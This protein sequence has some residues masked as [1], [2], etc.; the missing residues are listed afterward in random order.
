MVIPCASLDSNLGLFYM[1][2]LA[3]QYFIHFDVSKEGK[4]VEQHFSAVYC[5]L[6]KSW[7]HP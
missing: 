6:F 5:S 7:R 2:G 4:T 3:L 1:Q